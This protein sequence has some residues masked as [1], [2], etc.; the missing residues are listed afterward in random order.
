MPFD[1]STQRGT[2][3][4][5]I[6]LIVS[7]GSDSMHRG[8]LPFRLLEASPRAEM[9]SKVAVKGTPSALT[10]VAD[11]DGGPVPAAVHPPTSMPSPT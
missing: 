11:H 10:I 4:L 2:L 6:M 1:Q 5:G 9:K 8:R 3:L 7:C